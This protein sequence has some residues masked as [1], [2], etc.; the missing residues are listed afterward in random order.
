MA[1]ADRYYEQANPDLLHRIPVNASAVLEVGCG[2]GAL[3]RAFKSINPNTTYIGIELMPG[4][5]A[6]ARNVL[7]HVIEGDVSQE[8]LTTLPGDI[9]SVDC[10][11][12]GDVLEHLVDPGAVLR[13]LLPWLKEDGQLL[14]CIPN[15]QHWSVLANLLSG[16]WPQ[17]DQGLFDRTHLRW[18]T[19]QSITALIEEQGLHLQDITPRIFNPNKAKEFVTAL[20]P[21]LQTLN[22]NPQKVLEGSAPLQYVVRASKTR[23]KKFHISGLMLQP[24]AG[25]NEVRMIQPL[26]SVASFAGVSVQLSN[27][28]LPLSLKEPDI[29]RIM[30][31]QRQLLTYE[32][33]LDQLR[34]AIKAGFVLVSE[35]DDD[36]DLWP[37]IQDNKNLNFTA[38]HAVQTSTGA[39]ADKLTLF[40][41]NI[42]IFE[43]CLERLPDLN[44]EKWDKVGQ[45]N[46]LRLFFGALNREDS[47][48]EWIEPL[49]DVL[50][51]NPERWEVEVIHDKA[52]FDA[53]QTPYKRYSPTCN[54]AIY[55]EKLKQCHISLLPLKKTAFNEKKS[56]LKFVE[57]AGAQVATIASSTVY[58]D[59]IEPNKTGIICSE[60]KNLG[61][62]LNDLSN[63]PGK[64]KQ[65]ATN[66]RDW[67]QTHRLQHIQTQRRFEWYRSL[68][69]QRDKLTQELLNRVPELAN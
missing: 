34:M 42:A 25:M 44:P 36:P 49:N 4:P 43:N 31:W 9:Q 62:I 26:R 27:S 14:A 63:S 5:A 3:G 22:L 20:A 24:Q 59:I 11:V 12:F 66:A 68:W 21:A 2:A 13:Q 16:Q 52:F 46:R 65:I 48:K 8:V 38:M 39:L 40:N 69:E 53:L 10:L 30:I 35:F 32:K 23:A 60:G 64:A 67:C 61:D 15:V 51:N 29:P 18:F 41:P 28:H 37:A 45:E 58:G 7:D 56:D 6:Q 57:S 17:D 54:Y 19:K 33:S 50:R 47:W 55:M 1:P